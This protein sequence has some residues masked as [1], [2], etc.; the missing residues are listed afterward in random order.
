MDHKLSQT[1]F[2]N[3]KFM[4]EWLILDTFLV[5]YLELIASYSCIRSEYTLKIGKELEQKEIKSQNFEK[6]LKLLDC[7]VFD[8]MELLEWKNDELCK[9]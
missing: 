7:K 4:H 9:Y 1:S 8:Y 3:A 6:R 5:T 2:I